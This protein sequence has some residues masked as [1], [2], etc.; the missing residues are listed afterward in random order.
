MILGS[1]EVVALSAINTTLSAAGGT[2][3]ALGVLMFLEFMDTGHVVYD[4]IGASNGTLGGLVGITSACSVVEVRHLDLFL[5]SSFSCLR[6]KEACG[7][8]SSLLHSKL[9][10]AE[11]M[12]PWAA[13]IIGFLSGALYV[14]ASWF[15]ANKLK[16]DDPLDAVAVHCFCGAWGL[17]AAAL[18][19]AKAPTL[20]AYPDM[21]DNYGI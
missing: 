13:L 8:E 16:V 3:S 10:M 7:I 14:G 18:F 12:Q 11:C 1:S 19:A 15:V 20:A 5:L 21:G 6:Q 17:M 4:L 9:R 2:L